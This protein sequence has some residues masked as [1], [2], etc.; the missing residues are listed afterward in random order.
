VKAFELAGRGEL[1]HAELTAP[2]DRVRAAKAD[3]DSIGSEPQQPA[4]EEPSQAAAE[5]AP[6]S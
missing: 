2:I 6:P 4:A 3:L 5:S 1:S